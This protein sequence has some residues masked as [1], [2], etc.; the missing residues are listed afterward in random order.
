M[1][2]AMTELF[3]AALGLQSPWKVDQVRFALR[4]RRSTST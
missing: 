2:D 4:R 3:T 1:A